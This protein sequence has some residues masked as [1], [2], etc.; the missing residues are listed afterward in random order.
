MRANFVVSGVFAGIRRNAT[1]TIALVLSTAIALGFVGAAILAN[2]EI[3]KFR[4]KYEDKINVSVYLCAQLHTADPNCT[5]KTTP[6]QTAAI[7]QM[8]DSDPL[9]Q[10]ERYV[11]EQEAFQ[12]GKEQL[13][14]STGNFLHL[15]DL[16]ASFTV[17][18]K[19]L[20]KDYAAFAAKYAK[21]TGIGRVNNQIDT[22]NTLLNIIDSARWFSIII[23]I[24]VLVA[25]VLLIAN[26][27]QVA[28][29]QRKNETSI[30]RL[31]GASRWMTELPFMLEAVIAAA[32][33]GLVAIGLI[34][35]GKHYVLDNIFEG[36][37]RHGVIPNLSINDV[38]VA[39]GSGLIVGIVLSG[40]TAFLT[41]RFY[42][43]L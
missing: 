37:T 17:K 15:G 41:L 11:S 10:S 3:T 5:E 32:I 12:R 26:T 7:K 30:M 42:V 20:Q 14:G 35:A 33:G 8:L 18:L 31:V 39:G 13:A 29:S 9:V 2:T 4:Q 25:S 1:M 27:I 24:V 22:I 6:E 16:P 40:I 21:V 43:R 19:D 34:W 28:A 23:A 38:L 36:P